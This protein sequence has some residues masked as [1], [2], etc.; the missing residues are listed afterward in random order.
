MVLYSSIAMR[1]SVPTSGGFN[2]YNLI[3]EGVPMKTVNVKKLVAMAC[4]LCWMANTARA[5]DYG[6]KVLLCLSD[7]RGPETESQ[8]RPPIN[9]L[10]RDLAKGRP[11]PTCDMA[12][13]SSAKL[14]HNYY[15]ACPAGTSALAE[16]VAAVP[17]APA[18]AI[19][20]TFPS[21]SPYRYSDAVE[22]I[23]DGSKVV[24]HYAWGGMRDPMPTKACV[25]G[26]TGD[27]T[28]SSGGRYA[29]SIRAGIYDTMVLLPEHS[30][31]Q[32]ITVYIEGQVYH[33]V[34]F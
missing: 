25:A 24:P 15:D 4:V 33:Q 34:R 27:V 9:R 12:R 14:E 31:P 1:E 22:G 32:V 8:C 5:D 18:A 7:K 19:P 13:G 6:C 28:L 16:G 2:A 17:A 29:T 3:F 26:H 23:G 30:S 10:K 20:A 21:A 11:M